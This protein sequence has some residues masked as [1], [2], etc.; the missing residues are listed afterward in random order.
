M[1][2]I[3]SLNAHCLIVYP[4]PHIK[5]NFHQLVNPFEQGWT[6]APK[7]RDVHSGEPLSSRDLVGDDSSF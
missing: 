3:F 6:P 4:F 7:E 1:A 5:M 2:V